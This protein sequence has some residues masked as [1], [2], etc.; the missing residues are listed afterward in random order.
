MDFNLSPSFSPLSSL[1]ISSL[2]STPEFK[3]PG[4][5]VIIKL[6]SVASHQGNPDSNHRET[7]SHTVA[8]DTTEKQEAHVHCCWEISIVAG[9]HSTEVPQKLKMEV[10]GKS[11]TPGSISRR[12]E[13]GPQRHICPSAFTAA[14]LVTARFGIHILT[15]MCAHAHMCTHFKTGFIS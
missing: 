9:R 7:I 14:M 6:F 15:H 11:S 12:K 4:I 5:I 13:F 8:T 2:F 10:P 1:P 3:F